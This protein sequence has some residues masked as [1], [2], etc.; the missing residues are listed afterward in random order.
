MSEPKD[1][2][3]HLVQ[4]AERIDE[5]T[6]RHSKTLEKIVDDMRS[7]DTIA[8]ST[9]RIANSIETISNRAFTALEHKNKLD[10]RTFFFIALIIGTTIGLVL[11]LSTN[12][13]L[14]FDH[15]NSHIQVG[16]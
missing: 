11:L 9:S 3:N 12:T 7:L 6:Q 2:F 10:A 1:P 16:N 13:P 4:V 14:K 5:R 15:N 8:D